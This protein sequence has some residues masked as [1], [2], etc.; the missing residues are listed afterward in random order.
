MLSQSGP[1]RHRCQDCNHQHS[2]AT[3]DPDRDTEI[4][5]DTLNA[6]SSPIAFG[7]GIRGRHTTSATSA[8]SAISIDRPGPRAARACL[9]HRD[10]RDQHEIWTRRSILRPSAGG[11]GALGAGLHG[12]TSWLAGLGS[13]SC[14]SLRPSHAFQ[15]IIDPRAAGSDCAEGLAPSSSIL[16]CSALLSPERREPQSKARRES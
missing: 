2:R 8:T 7:P 5:T 11:A 15:R 4:A 3:A 1:R 12:W 14:L 9:L 6:L 13:C 10:R 16:G